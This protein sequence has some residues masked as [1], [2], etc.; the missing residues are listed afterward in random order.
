M[1]IVQIRK[2]RKTRKDWRSRSLKLT[3]CNKK[4]HFKYL[5]YSSSE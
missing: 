2:S 1:A 3:D 4:Y 5:E